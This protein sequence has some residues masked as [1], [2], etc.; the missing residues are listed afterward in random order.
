VNLIAAAAFA[1]PIFPL[2]TQEQIGIASVNQA[3]QD[4]IGWPGYVSQ[5]A[6]VYRTLPPDEAA[7][8]ILI[9]S[10]YGEYGAIARYGAARA[11]PVDRL[12]SGQNELRNLGTPPDSADVAVVVGI[13]DHSA[14]ASRFDDC[15]IEGR[16]ESGYD[17]DNEEQDRSIEVCRGPREPWRTLWPRFYHYD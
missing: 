11:L 12:Y 3:T 1:L 4:Q 9:T 6:A 10:N 16:L 15:T 13:D 7:R 2:S 8:A 14:L 5:I 17:I